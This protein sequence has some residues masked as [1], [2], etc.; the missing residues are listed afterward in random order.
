MVFPERSSG[1]DWNYYI[2]GAGAFEFDEVFI[3]ESNGRAKVRLKRSEEDTYTIRIGPQH[4]EF[5]HQDGL[6]IP[7]D[8]LRN[9][10]FDLLLSKM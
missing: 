6:S 8:K 2:D 4:G 10:D 1:I 3:E 5:L 7:Y 9:A